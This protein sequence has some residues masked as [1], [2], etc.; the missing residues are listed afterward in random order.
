MDRGEWS[1][2]ERMSLKP[3]LH[4]IIPT[5][6]HEKIWFNIIH[7][8][9]S[10]QYASAAFAIEHQNQQKLIYWYEILSEIRNIVDIQSSVLS[11]NRLF[12]ESPAS[13]A[14]SVLHLFI[15]DLKY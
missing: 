8:W 9:A 10:P 2:V 7:T 13:D 4:A 3:P 5:M 14:F 11:K 12:S 15:H 6:A 1:T